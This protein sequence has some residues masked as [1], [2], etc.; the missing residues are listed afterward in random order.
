LVKSTLM[1]RMFPATVISTFFIPGSPYFKLRLFKR[2]AEERISD[3][4]LG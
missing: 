1:V 4:S 2:R 3:N